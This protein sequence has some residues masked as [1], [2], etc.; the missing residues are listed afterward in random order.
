LE[1]EE[2]EEEKKEEEDAQLRL[3]RRAKKV[4]VAFVAPSLRDDD[5]EDA[6][7]VVKIGETARIVNACTNGSFHVLFGFFFAFWPPPKAELL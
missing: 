5:D 6:M 2:E 3:T 7:T 1:E 4:S